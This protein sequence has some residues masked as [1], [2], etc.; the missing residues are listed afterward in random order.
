MTHCNPL[1]H[2]QAGDAVTISVVLDSIEDV[3]ERMTP[4]GDSKD[5]ERRMVH[6]CYCST[7]NPIS[8]LQL[9]IITQGQSDITNQRLH[10]YGIMG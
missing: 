4:S 6:I 1:H 5:P 2:Q 3:P 9:L 8:S 7:V 10:N